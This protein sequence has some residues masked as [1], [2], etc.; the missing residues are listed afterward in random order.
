VNQVVIGA[1]GQFSFNGDGYS[2]I[3]GTAE[4]WTQTGTTFAAGTVLP[5]TASGDFSLVFTQ[6]PSAVG[7]YAF[8]LNVTDQNA[9]LKTVTVNVPVAGFGSGTLNVSTPATWHEVF[10]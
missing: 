8:S 6:T 7:T 1:P 10:Q 5:I 9:I 3:N 4:D 2:L